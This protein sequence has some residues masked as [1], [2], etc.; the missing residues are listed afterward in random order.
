[1]TMADT[2]QLLILKAQIASDLGA[3]DRIEEAVSSAMTAHEP[4]AT[5]PQIV[6]S[7][8][9]L[10]LHDFYQAVE[11]VLVRITRALNGFDTLGEAWHVDLLRLSSLDVEGLRPAVISDSTR[12]QLDRYRSFRHFVRHGYDRDFMWERMKDLVS[13]LPKVVTLF[14]EDVHR[15]LDV[16]D[17]M[18]RE[19]NEE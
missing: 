1:M 5:P 2:R 6:R 17:Q 18:A 11:Q 8:L 15:F 19:L 10:Y 13:D 14:E 16:L 12:V 3:I 7:G 9:A 4:E